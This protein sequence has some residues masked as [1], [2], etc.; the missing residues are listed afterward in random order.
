MEAFSS[1]FVRQLFL[2]SLD[3]TVVIL[4]SYYYCYCYYYHCFYDTIQ[5]LFSLL[6][7]DMNDRF[8]VIVT[9]VLSICFPL[10]LAWHYYYYCNHY[11]VEPFLIL[12]TLSLLSSDFSD[13][14][15]L[16]TYTNSVTLVLQAI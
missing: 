3:F 8:L 11:F 13:L 1:S 4:A 14:C 5:F 15:C 7:T 2:G 9:I 6:S 10:I 16:L 12:L